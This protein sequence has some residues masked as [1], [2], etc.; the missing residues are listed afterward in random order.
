LIEKINHLNVVLLTSN[1]DGFV[2]ITIID[3]W[4]GN[5]WENISNNV[6]DQ[7]NIILHEFGDNDISQG[8]ENKLML[9]V[10][11]EFGFEETGCINDRLHSSHTIIIMILGGKLLGTESESGHHLLGENS[12]FEETEGIKLD[13]S[14]QCIIRNHHS[15]WSEKS[16]K[17][18][19]K[20]RTSSITWIKGNENAECWLHL[21][22]TF[23]EF[24]FWKSPT[25]GIEK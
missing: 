17:V 11:L 4:F 18:I 16:L 2:K 5:T 9:I 25:L 24:N 8:S 22:K 12:T 19:W 23:F 1:A 7:W 6:F 10:I 3:F 15:D 21:D 13:F 14:N 20:L